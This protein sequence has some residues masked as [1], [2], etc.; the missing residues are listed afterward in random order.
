MFASPYDTLQNETVF[1]YLAISNK[2][3]QIPIFITPHRRLCISF[4]L[5]A[6]YLIGNTAA[7]NQSHI[8]PQKQCN[9]LV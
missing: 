8:H 3:F 9:A 4:D 7:G 5:R 6:F 1:F 2:Q